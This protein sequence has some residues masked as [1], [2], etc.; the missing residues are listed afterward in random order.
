[1]YRNMRI[2]ILSAVA[3]TLVIA[4]CSSDGSDPV[5]T[6]PKQ[7]TVAPVIAGT[8][9]RA[10]YS[11]NSMTFVAGDRVSIYAWTGNRSSIADGQMVVNGTANT[12]GVDGTWTSSPQMLWGDMVTPHYFLGI[13]PER[14][15]TDFE[16]DP[17]TLTADYAAD[18][19]LA[20]TNVTGIRATDDPVGIVFSHLMTRLTVSLS[21]K[22]QWDGVPD[23][24]TVTA[25]SA[26]SATVDYLQHRVTAT[27][28]PAS[29]SLTA[30]PSAE[31]TRA[32]Q[33][34]LVP[35]Q[36]FRQ[37]TAVVEGQRFVYTHP[38]DIPLRS[39]TST[40]VHLTLGRNVIELAGVSIDDWSESVSLDGTVVRQ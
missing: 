7:L 16:A 13:Y 34:I 12:L 24:V 19:L 6:A 28:T 25:L 23:D 4:G 20:G 14:S 33:G 30:A 27:G 10:A 32:F 36:G 35:Q 5:A 18:D 37:I 21:F 31:G 38:D 29:Q 26:G 40:T 3:L 2:S 9:T 1:M 17:F 15:V 8:P 22:N 11:G 39:G